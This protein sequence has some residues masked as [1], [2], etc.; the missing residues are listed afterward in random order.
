MISIIILIV[1]NAISSTWASGDGC[2]YQINGTNAYINLKPLVKNV[3]LN[4]RF[5]ARDTEKWYYAFQ[6]CGKFSLYLNM[7]LPNKPCNQTS[8]A[9]FFNGSLH[10]CVGL[11]RTCDFKVEKH[12]HK[13][14]VS[15]MTLNYRDALSSSKEGMVISLICNHAL[16][17]NESEFKYVNV[18][19]GTQLTWYFSLESRCCCPNGCPNESSAAP[20]KGSNAVWYIVGI[21]AAVLFVIIVVFIIIYAKFYPCSNKAERQRLL[22]EPA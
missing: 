17:L 14:I 20:K 13:P 19:R 8:T 21:T 5:I 12:Y 3:N 10:E 1:A 4:P 2:N 9:R 22:E 16:P 11:G 6:P 7:S 15:N 18:S